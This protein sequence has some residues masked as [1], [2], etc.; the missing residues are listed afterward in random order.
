MIERGQRSALGLP[1]CDCYDLNQDPSQSGGMSKASQEGPMGKANLLLG[2]TERSPLS[3]VFG[4]MARCPT[5][6]RLGRAPGPELHDTRPKFH[7]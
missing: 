1:F 7:C 3:S 2:A 5:N 4:T 6:C